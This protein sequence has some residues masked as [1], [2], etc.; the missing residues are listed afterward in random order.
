MGRST[1]DL[2]QAFNEIQP[3]IVHFS[4]HGTPKAELVLEDKDGN[5]LRVTEDAL[6][7]LFKNVTDN[8]RLVVLNACHSE[9]QARVISQHV[10]CTIGMSME[11]GD[12]A[13]IIFASMFYGAL[14]FG[15]SVGHAFEQAKTALML[16]GVPEEKT[17][18]LLTRPTADALMV[19]IRESKARQS[20][21]PTCCLANPRK[22]SGWKQSSSHRSL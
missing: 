11:V 10:E 12:E 8:I 15:R 7:S 4:S 2:L 21:P 1:L 13:A 3:D 16:Q 14:A 18:V 19:S 17:P 5:A 9:A 22:C 6:A 20:C